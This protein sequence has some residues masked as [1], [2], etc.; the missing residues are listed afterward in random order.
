[1]FLMI[2]S[3][4]DFVLIS[5]QWDNRFGTDAETKLVLYINSI[6]KFNFNFGLKSPKKLT[7][8]ILMR[9]CEDFMSNIFHERQDCFS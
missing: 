5:F 8:G 7:K 3:D 4:L 9:R 2:G 1:M 6:Y